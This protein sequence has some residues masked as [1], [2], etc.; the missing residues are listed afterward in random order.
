MNKKTIIS[1]MLLCGMP[2]FSFAEEPKLLPPATAAPSFS[3]P[4]INGER[5]SAQ[6]IAGKRCRNRIRIKSV[7]R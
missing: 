5:V 2:V 1:I 3:L 7:R 4:T 6:L